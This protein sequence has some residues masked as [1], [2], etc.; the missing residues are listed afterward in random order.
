MVFNCSFF[1]EYVSLMKF[2]M[3][4]LFHYKDLLVC[5]Q[6]ELCNTN[7]F[8]KKHKSIL[9]YNFLLCYNFNNVKKKVIGKFDQQNREWENEF[10]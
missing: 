7:F 4:E 10:F 9:F 3:G 2:C 6:L 5:I 1:S 8:L